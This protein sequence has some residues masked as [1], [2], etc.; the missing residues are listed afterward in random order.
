MS[1]AA[2]EELAA[3]VVWPHAARAASLSVCFDPLDGS[4]NTDVAGVVGTIFGV[5]PG[6]GPHEPDPARA[7]LGAGTGQIA[8][9]YILYGPATVFVY[10]AGARVHAFVLDPVEGQFRL[11][12]ADTRMPPAGRTYAVNDANWAVLAP[13]GA[14]ARRAAPAGP[15]ARTSPTLSG[16]RA[17]WS[18]TSTGRSSRAASI[19]TPRTRGDRRGASGSCTRR[20]RSR[21]WRRRRA[22]ARAPA[23][24]G[25]STWSPPTITSARRSTSAAR[26][27]SSWAERCL[28]GRR[29]M[30]R[31]RR[32]AGARPRGEDAG[33]LAGRPEPLLP[34]RQRRRPDRSAR[35]GPC[36]RSSGSAPTNGW[37][38]SGRTWRRRTA[39]SS[40]TSP[41]ARTRRRSGALG[42]SG[43]R[44]RCSSGSRAGAT[45]GT[46]M[47]G[48]PCGWPCGSIAAWNRASRPAQPAGFARDLPR[49]PAHERRGGVSAARHRGRADRAVRAGPRP[50]PASRG[51][52][53]SAARAPRPFYARNGFTDLAALEVSPGRWVYT[54]GRRRS[55]PAGRQVAPTRRYCRRRVSSVSSCWTASCWRP[56][57]VWHRSRSSRETRSYSPRSVSC[58]A[59]RP[60]SARV[61]SE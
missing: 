11:T 10:A 38:R 58:S 28:P 19:S 56:S 17:P 13:G 32:R 42:G 27:R 43:S 1:V 57:A 35:A 30:T 22:D 8:A 4:L 31:E 24:R 55:A 61:V 6:P 2:S 52:I 7:V 29:G 39:G 20:R 21:S 14:R 36:S 40:A 59:R 54:L 5:R 48:G 16:T 47:P 53:S 26:R 23:A 44:S 37:C 33:G 15:D 49:P 9:G 60:A 50:P 41:A 12:Q 51:S 3:P 45:R 34:H 18:R 46:R 25:S